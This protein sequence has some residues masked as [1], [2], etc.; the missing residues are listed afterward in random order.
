MGQAVTVMQI[1]EAARQAA[2]SVHA[3][4][5]YERRSLLPKVTRSVGRFRLY[6]AS[7]V[8][9]LRFIQQMQGLGF[10]LREIRQLLDLRERRLD[11]CHEVRDL[12]KTKLG[13]IRSKIRELET[14]EREL[15][16]DLKKCNLE[17]RH[18]AKHPARACPV[19]SVATG[20]TGG[21]KC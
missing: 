20:T 2:L 5:F 21:K 16:D 12:M 19:L 4:R 1:G 14:L 13:T 17:L 6:T 8:A 10:S 11:A 3:I 18:R 15:A 7:D 9:R